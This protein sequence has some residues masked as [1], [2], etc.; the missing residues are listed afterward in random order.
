M[1][2]IENLGCLE[3]LLLLNNKIKGIHKNILYETP[4]PNLSIY[5]I[6]PKVKSIKLQISS[7][8]QINKELLNISTFEYESKEFFFFVCFSKAINEKKNKYTGIFLAVRNNAASV[9]SSCIVI[10]DNTIYKI[11]IITNDLMKYMKYLL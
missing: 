5:G 7:I 10:E 11:G 8:K 2:K 4:N 9:A 6:N 1:K 3:F